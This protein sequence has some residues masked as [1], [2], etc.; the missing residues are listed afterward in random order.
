MGK[1]QDFYSLI[2]CTLILSVAACLPV[3]GLHEAIAAGFEQ[4]LTS[5]GITFHVVSVTTGASSRVKITLSGAG[6]DPGPVESRI[7]GAVTWAEVTDDLD[8]DGSPELYVYA[9]CPEEV[10]SEGNR[11]AYSVP[12]VAAVITRGPHAGYPDQ[13]VVIAVPGTGSSSAVVVRP[14]VAA[15]TD[16]GIVQVVPVV[17]VESVE[18][19]KCI[20]ELKFVLAGTGKGKTLKLQSR[21]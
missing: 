20:H 17:P 8:N 15:R 12:P 4:E 11:D 19:E 7:D 14:A 6:V 5:G 10:S 2:F 9:T 16:S 13:T 18:D 1:F 21:K 3:A